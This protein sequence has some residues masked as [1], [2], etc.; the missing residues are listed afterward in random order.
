MLTVLDVL[1]K[2]ALE[3]EVIERLPCAIRLLPIPKTSMEFHDF[4]EYERLVDAARATD[5]TTLVIVL[6]GGD[7][8]LRC[9]E[10]MALRWSDVDRRKRQICVEQSNW[11]GHVTTT[12]GGPPSPGS[13]A[14]G[15]G[16]G[17]S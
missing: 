13:C 12:K 10:M 15:G 5:S 1:L 7:A 6:L 14:K 8:G 3:W 2:K 9:G 4:D 16:G 17:G 11:K